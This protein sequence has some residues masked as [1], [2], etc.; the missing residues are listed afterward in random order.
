MRIACATLVLLLVLP[1]CG[2][3]Q[4]P[5]GPSLSKTP[6]SIRGW[7]VDV[8]PP[9]GSYRVADPYAQ[10][11]QKAETLRNTAMWIENMPF[12][13]GGLGE[14]GAFILLDVPPGKAVVTFQAPGLQPG[15]LTLENVPGNADIVI[16]DVV[17]ANGKIDVADPSRIVA[18]IG[19]NEQTGETTVTVQG[20]RVPLKRVPMNEL[21]DRHEYPTIEE[22]TAAPKPA[23]PAK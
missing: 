4:K 7:V 13:S 19:D 17:I 18:R 10:A 2:K 1:G 22:K 21:S 5:S 12:V 3:Q 15:H 9:A 11:S 20:H 6:V 8:E 23:V 14:T 16:P